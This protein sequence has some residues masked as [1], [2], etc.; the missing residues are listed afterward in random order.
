MVNDNIFTFER[1]QYLKTWQPIPNLHLPPEQIQYY[2]HRI[3]TYGVDIRYPE[4]VLNEAFADILNKK[5]EKH[6]IDANF[7]K[8]LVL[9]HMGDLINYIESKGVVLGDIR[10]NIR[11]IL[12]EII[13]NDVDENYYINTIKI[14]ED[15][16]E[17]GPNA[18]IYTLLDQA[19]RLGSWRMI[20][21]LIFKE[22]ENI[23]DRLSE[24][25]NAEVI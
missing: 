24:V 11:Q 6:N 3:Q 7:L 21:Y 10:W 14:Y 15:I 5:Y 1:K 2:N 16:S 22:D 19:I 18:D 4:N 25:I 9:L 13:N 20:Y 17:E 8:H 23:A 12:N